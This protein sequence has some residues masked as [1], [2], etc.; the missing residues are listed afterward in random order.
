M[1]IVQIFLIGLIVLGGALLLNGFANVLGLKT[2]YDFVQSVQNT[3]F[4]SLLWLF[5][6]YPLMLGVLA[7]IAMKLVVRT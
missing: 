7:Y 1:I 4:W 5:V 6:A 3:S 2:W